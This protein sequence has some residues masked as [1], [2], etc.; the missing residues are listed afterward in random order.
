MDSKPKIFELILAGDDKH[1]QNYLENNPFEIFEAWNSFNVF[2]Y[3]SIF[4]NSLFKTIVHFYLLNKHIFD[5]QNL[6][7]FICRKDLTGN[8]PLHYSCMFNNYNNA[9]LILEN[10]CNS[11]V[12]NASDETPLI[13]SIFSN[14]LS[15]IKLLLNYNAYLNDSHINLAFVLHHFDI[16]KYLVKKLGISKINK[17]LLLQLKN[18]HHFSHFIN[19]ELNKKKNTYSK[20]KYFT[21]LKNKYKSLCLNPESSLLD[22]Q[23]MSSKLNINYHN[24]SK[25]DLCKLISQK[26]LTSKII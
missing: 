17:N 3:A 22:I 10:G 24:K 25:K 21:Y 4:K 19:S 8:S 2:T 20:L 26:L 1:L 23:Y 16:V 15:L 14:S 12:V 7:N 18:N 5:A 13:L 11:N 9:K 6:P